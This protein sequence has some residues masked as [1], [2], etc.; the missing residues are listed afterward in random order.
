MALKFATISKPFSSR[1]IRPKIGSA[2]FGSIGTHP[3]VKAICIARTHQLC[4]SV[5]VQVNHTT[6]A[7]SNLSTALTKWSQYFL[8]HQSHILSSLYLLSQPF[9]VCLNIWNKHTDRRK[10]TLSEINLSA[11][12]ILFFILYSYFYYH[13]LNCFGFIHTKLR[14]MSIPGRIWRSNHYQYQ[15]LWFHFNDS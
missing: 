12:Y 15:F 4:Q 2:K 8:H 11:K 13:F 14:H 5:L 1:K 10:V 9:F 7:G 3:D 6:L